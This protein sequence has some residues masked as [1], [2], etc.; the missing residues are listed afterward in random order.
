M[1][2]VNLLLFKV[3]LLHQLIKVDYLEE[4]R[5]Q[6]WP[7]YGLGNQRNN[8]NT[9]NFLCR[10]PVAKKIEQPLSELQQF[11]KGTELG[12]CYRLLCHL[13]T[14]S[15]S[16]HELWFFDSHFRIRID[17]II[18]GRLGFKTLL[19]ARSR[20]NERLWKATL[21]YVMKNAILLEN[22][23]RLMGSGMLLR[24]KPEPNVLPRLAQLIQWYQE[25]PPGNREEL[26]SSGVI[27]EV[28][29]VVHG[30]LL[31][32]WCDPFSWDKLATRDK[33]LLYAPC[34]INEGPLFIPKNKSFSTM[35]INNLNK[36]NPR[37][38]L[39]Q[40]WIIWDYLSEDG[41]S[42]ASGEQ[43]AMWRLRILGLIESVD[44]SGL[45]P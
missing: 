20:G 7:N 8:R 16:I 45:I 24:V 38:A 42:P 13:Y 37:D 40:H 9:L 28:L 43:L 23:Y 12:E 33:W 15:P 25:N 17:N 35:L 22:Q 2:D 10:A 5:R 36:I 11:L 31:D 19:T 44:K 41:I 29:E 1:I 4:A 21:T 26:L 32:T 39:Q 18:Q 34:A 3:L 14:I 6:A 27:E 30:L